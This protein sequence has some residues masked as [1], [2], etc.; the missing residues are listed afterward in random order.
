MFK[1]VFIRTV[2]VVEVALFAWFVLSWL[3]VV[4]T[5]TTPTPIADWNMFGLLL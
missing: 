2:T 3:N 1:K 5:N 4:C